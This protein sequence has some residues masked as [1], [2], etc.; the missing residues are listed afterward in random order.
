MNKQCPRRTRQEGGRG[1]QTAQGSSGC[2][3]N[4]QQKSGCRS[5]TEVHGARQRTRDVFRSAWQ[6][7]DA[8]TDP[9]APRKSRPVGGGQKVVP[10]AMAVAAGAIS[11]VAS[12]QRDRSLLGAK[13]RATPRPAAGVSDAGPAAQR[14]PGGRK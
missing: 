7:S 3:L 11:H 2:H 4:T 5:V 6:E 9:L 1:P 12:S 10:L 8:L 14:A 13:S